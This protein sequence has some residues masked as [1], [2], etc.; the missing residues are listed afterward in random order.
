[1]Y[2]AILSNL[3]KYFLNISLFLP[4]PSWSSLRDLHLSLIKT[5]QLD[6][7]FSYSVG[8]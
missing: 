5:N 6:L 4:Y 1:M 7:E 2:I 3:V 8:I